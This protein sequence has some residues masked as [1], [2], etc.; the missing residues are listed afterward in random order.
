[1]FKTT[2]NY[3]V[4]PKTRLDK[5]FADGLPINSFIDKGRCAIGAT[6]GEIMNKTRSTIIVVPNISIIHNKHLS[7]PDLDVVFGEK[8]YKDVEDLLRDYKSGQKIMTTPEGMKK[9]MDAATKL[10]RLNEFKR[11][12]F[13]L[14]DEAHTFITENYRED[15]LVPFNYF[16]DFFDQRSII[17]A[18]PYFFSDKRFYDLTFHKIT[19]NAPLGTVR[20]INAKSVVGTLDYILKHLDEFPGNVHIF[21]NSVTEIVNAIIRAA[22]TSC[23]INCANDKDGKNMKKLGDYVKFF[24]DEPNRELYQKVNFYTCKYFEGWDMF[25][26]DAT[27]ILVTDVHKPHTKIGVSTK[28]KQAI[29]RLRNDPKEDSNLYQIMHI[30]NHGNNK[31]MK[32]LDTIQ[33]EF[34]VEADLLIRQ[35]EERVTLYNQ[36]DRK[37]IQDER[38]IKFADVDNETKLAKIQLMKLDQQINEA[39]NNEIYN[40]IDFIQKDWEDAYYEV[41]YE[42][43][44]F[45]LETS[46]ALKRKSR[47]TQLKEDYQR[48][49]EYRST[50][51]SSNVFDIARIVEQG[52]KESN[53]LAYAAYKLLDDSKMDELKFNVKKV[54][55]AVILKEN[56]LVEVK[57]MKLLNNEFRANNFYTNEQIKSKLQKI[58]SELNIR[59]DNGKIRV[60]SATQLSEKGRFETRQT[61]RKNDR[62]GNDD[63][64]YVIL[65]PQFALRMAA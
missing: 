8:S 5:I 45:V 54:Q 39:A 9:I 7:H 24:V 38:L 28:G 64:G 62:T 61:K 57:L 21:Y 47:N 25:D 17:S 65:R 34:L 41:T 56:N 10:G 19:F 36:Q 11:D 55:A 37:I 20:L 18:T 29:G 26:K 58:Y 63:H 40:H 15:I 60:A 42:E 46:T 22:L 27:V 49:K 59:G 48:L 13:L 4:D 52:I 14:L 1:M 16:W 23:T 30:T 51:S 43:T 50:Q 53:P 12:W 2:K 3:I 32:S 31:T 35:N 6:Y 44:D 33:Q